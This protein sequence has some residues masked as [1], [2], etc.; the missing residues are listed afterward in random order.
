[1]HMTNAV[2]FPWWQTPCISL[3]GSR[4]LLNMV[5]NAVSDWMHAA[6]HVWTNAVERLSTQLPI[7]H[8]YPLGYT[9]DTGMTIAAGILMMRSHEWT[10]R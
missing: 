1:M 3:I 8:C 9:H 6:V 7:P 10:P 4:L 5:L 2:V